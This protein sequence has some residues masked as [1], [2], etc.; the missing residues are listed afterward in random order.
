MNRKYFL[1]Y[2][3]TLFI[4]GCSKDNPKDVAHKFLSA[5]A[6][7][8]YDEAKKYATPATAKLLEML[9]AASDLTPDSVK[10]RMEASF[11]IVK[12]YKRNDTLAIVLYHMKNSDTDQ[13]LNVVKRDGKWLVN[14]SKEEFNSRELEL[15]A[16]EEEM[17]PD[18]TSASGG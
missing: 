12:E 6:R 15:P 14:V 4:A 16:E 11:E 2:F 9:S 5:S 8:E 7:M 3:L 10:K 13:T 18:T 1:L 17:E